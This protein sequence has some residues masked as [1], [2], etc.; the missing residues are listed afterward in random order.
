MDNCFICG[1]PIDEGVQY[2][3]AHRRI[4]HGSRPWCATPGGHYALCDECDHVLKTYVRMIRESRIETGE[5][6]DGA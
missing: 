4:H 2:I 1:R 6:N 5:E 3:E